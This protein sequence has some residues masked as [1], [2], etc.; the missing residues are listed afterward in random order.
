[1]P[2]RRIVLVGLAASAAAGPTLAQQGGEA[3]RIPIELS[4]DALALDAAIRAGAK[5]GDVTLIEFFDYNCPFC[6]RSAKDMTALLASDPDLTY[7]L[8]NYAVLGAPSVEA[9]RVALA[10]ARQ[11]GPE[12][13]LAFHQSLFGTRGVRGAAV[14][15]EKAKALGADAA[16]LV[17]DADSAPVTAAMK[18]AVQLGERLGLVATPSYV[19]GPWSF[20]GHVPLERKRRII[21][22]IRL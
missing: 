12:K 21:E 18:Q 22:S 13:Y 8:V 4:E 17:A 9:T 10:F 15:V 2:T 1:M 3:Q 7:V 6:A 16:R 19:V 14:A 5:H 20:A 11:A